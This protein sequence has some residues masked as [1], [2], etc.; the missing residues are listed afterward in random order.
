M[1]TLHKTR[2][3]VDWFHRL[4][5]Q[6]AKNRILNRIRRAENG[7]FGDHHSLGDG[8][9][10]MRVDHGPGYRVYY[11]QKERA[12][13]LLLIGGDKRNQNSDIETAKAMWR[14]LGGK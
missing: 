5:D 8:V 13:Y 6:N 7:N 12:V 14:V 2:A 11:A 9:S 4:S 3:Y 10:E 1:N